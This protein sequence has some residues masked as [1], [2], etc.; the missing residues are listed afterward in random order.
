MKCPRCE[1]YCE[2]FFTRTKGKTRYGMCGYCFLKFLTSFGK[3]VITTENVFTGKKTIKT[4][5]A[6]KTANVNR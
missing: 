6:R 5:K 4:I 1:R 3:K 2:V